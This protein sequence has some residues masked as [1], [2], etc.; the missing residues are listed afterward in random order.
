MTAEFERVA[1]KKIVKSL[2]PL[3]VGECMDLTFSLRIKQY[4]LADWLNITPQAISIMLRRS[5]VSPIKLSE[6]YALH[7][8]FCKKVGHTPIDFYTYKHKTSH[9]DKKGGVG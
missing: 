9:I 3:T 5:P 2:W 8:L 1:V 6:R 7:C 4:E